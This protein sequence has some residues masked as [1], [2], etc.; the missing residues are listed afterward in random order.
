M[1]L[2]DDKLIYPQLLRFAENLAVKNYESILTCYLS[3]ELRANADP[4]VN[5][6]GSRVTIGRS[7]FLLAVRPFYGKASPPHI[8]FKY[9]EVAFLIPKIDKHNRR[10]LSV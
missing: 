8:V 9:F 3:N 6:N 10:G 2:S 4:K 1:V 5:L 7:F